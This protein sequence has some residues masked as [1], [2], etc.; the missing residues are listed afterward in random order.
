LFQVFTEEAWFMS[1]I[2]I[3]CKAML[4]V[5]CMQQASVGFGMKK[6][7]LSPYCCTKQTGDSRNIELFNVDMTVVRDPVY[8]LINEIASCPF[9][10]ELLKNSEEKLKKAL[11]KGPLCPGKGVR[12]IAQRL[13]L[14]RLTKDIY[15]TLIE[16]CV[17]K[18]GKKEAD[19][20]SEKM[21]EKLNT[22]IKGPDLPDAHFTNLDFLEE[23]FPKLQFE[24]KACRFQDSWRFYVRHVVDKEVLGEVNRKK[25]IKC[26]SDDSSPQ[27]CFLRKTLNDDD[28]KGEWSC[29]FGGNLPAIFFALEKHR[30][31]L[32]SSKKDQREMKKLFIQATTGVISDAITEVNKKLYKEKLVEASGNGLFY[33]TIIRC[34][35]P[36]AEERLVYEKK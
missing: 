18:Q 36:N 28:Q 31:P 4:V 21:K 11:Q 7:R 15:L 32:L 27:Q 34:P 1:K 8:L 16:Y 10:K 3:F 6:E 23:H 2:S 22:C 25:L 19:I 35:Y 20:V 9:D 14:L 29:F 5:F 30:D 26:F 17:L 24:K 33:D 12:G 13:S